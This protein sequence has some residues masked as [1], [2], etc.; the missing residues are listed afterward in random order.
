[1][2]QVGDS[3]QVADHLVEVETAKA[4]FPVESPVAGTLS[5]ILAPEGTTVAMTAP[6][7]LVQPS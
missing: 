1:M 5:E 7:C 3:V 6:L 4:L 2:K